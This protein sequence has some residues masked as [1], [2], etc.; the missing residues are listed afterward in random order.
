MATLTTYSHV[1]HLLQ[2]FSSGV[3][4]FLIL[5]GDA[6][7]GKSRFVSNFLEESDIYHVKIQG[8]ITAIQFYETLYTFQDAIIVLDDIPTSASMYD[9]W[10]LLLQVCQSEPVKTV[11][12]KTRGKLAEGIPSQFE[13]TSRIV[14]LCNDWH[15]KNTYAPALESRGFHVKFH[16]TSEEI[17]QYAQGF[18]LEEVIQ[19]FQQYLPFQPVINLRQLHYAQQLLEKS[20]PW[21]LPTI[22][23]W[24]LPVNTLSYVLIDIEFPTLS[25]KE[26]CQIWCQTNRKPQSV[27]QR[28]ADQL[29]Q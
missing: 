19:F 22:E 29:E 1:E 6:G 11:N 17:L 15:A 10:N 20:F 12:W 7:I 27:Y 28:L 13:T 21:Q 3:Y 4:D 16:P 5:E 9:F 24:H 8:K 26:K 23:Q 18:I 25:S 14:Y 2:T